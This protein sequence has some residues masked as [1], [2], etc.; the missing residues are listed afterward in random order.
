MLRGG[1][2]DDQLQAMFMKRDANQNSS[3]DPK[4][5]YEKGGVYQV[6]KHTCAT[7]A[8]K[9]F[10]KCLAGTS[11][12]FCFGKD[13]HKVRDCPNILAGER[14]DT[15]VPPNAPYVGAPNRNHLY[16]LRAKGTKSDDDYDIG[17]L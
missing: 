7:W 3:S 14:G 13:D 9:N 5:N 11:G 12:C 10:G 8:M 6:V 4:A 16:A 1:K 17:K 2:T 15:E